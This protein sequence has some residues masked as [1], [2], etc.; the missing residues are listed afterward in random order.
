MVRR[1]PA[2]E[3]NQ[4]NE[5]N[6]NEE[7]QLPQNEVEKRREP[8]QVDAP[9]V[10]QETTSSSEKSFGALI[11]VII[12]VAVLVAGGVYLWNRTVQE[13]GEN[14]QL[15]VIQSGGETDA[16]VNQLESQGTSDEIDA[17]EKD[18][19]TTDLEVFDTEL[20][21]ILNELL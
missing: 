8:Q 15:P 2:A 12:I 1:T 4:H 14:E 3:I 20:N 19:G 21:G 13:K 6:M 7:A 11:G 18:L 10:S 17:I 9:E 5:M 16:I